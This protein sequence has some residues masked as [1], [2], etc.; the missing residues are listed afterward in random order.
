M[1]RMASGVVALSVVAPLLGCGFYVAE[2]NFYREKPDS[3]FPYTNPRGRY[4][5]KNVTHLVCEVAN[6]IAA[7]VARYDL[8][9]LA[10]K[11]WG[12]AITLTITA[13]DQSGLSPGLSFFKPFGNHI[14]TFP[15][16]GPVTASQ[17]FTL[18]VGA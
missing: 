12:T 17:S 5:N 1:H 4:E 10:S 2:K 9:W 14:F 11:K 6:G 16:G 7:V 15:S 18:G 8:P 13:Q 3:A